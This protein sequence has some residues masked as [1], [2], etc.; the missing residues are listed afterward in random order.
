[1][2]V[3]A[4]NGKE[5]D[6]KMR[7]MIEKFKLLLLT[8]EHWNDSGIIGC[9]VGGKVRRVLEKWRTLWDR[10]GDKWLGSKRQLVDRAMRRTAHVVSS[11]SPVS[12]KLGR[13]GLALS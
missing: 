12:S 8:D 7:A 10:D 1:M 5:S 6:D 2:A 3:G 11:S 9:E 4:V 13:K